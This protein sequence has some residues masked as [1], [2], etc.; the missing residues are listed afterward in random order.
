MPGEEIA[1]AVEADAAIA[2][3]DVIDGDGSIGFDSLGSRE[4]H[5]SQQVEGVS[6]ADATLVPDPDEFHSPDPRQISLERIQAWI[7]FAVLLTGAMV[8]LV[9]T[10]IASGLTSVFLLVFGGVFTLLALI[11]WHGLAWPAVAHRYNKWRLD[12]TGLEIRNGVFW[13][14]QVS[15]PVARVQ[16]V[17]VLQGPLQRRFGLG[18]VTV[19]TAGT[20]NASVSFEG[21]AYEDACQLRDQLIQ[22]REALD[23]V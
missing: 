3:G 6:V 18:T 16:H 14:H 8:G 5:D 11:L 10:L 17:D 22:Q 20:T 12:E 1:D 19:H 7:V 9:I 2:S 15:V 23:V 21:F 13:R 4:I